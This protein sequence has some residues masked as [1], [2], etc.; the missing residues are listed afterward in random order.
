[1][2]VLILYDS[3]TGNTEKIVN[4][5]YKTLKNY[6]LEKLEKIKITKDFSTDFE[7]LEYDTIFLGSPVIQ[8]LPSVNLMNFCKKT[9]M[10][11]LK[12]GHIIP[13]SPKIEGKYGIPFVSY[14]GMHTGIKEAIPALKYLQQFLEHLR[15]NV[16]DEFYV[17]GEYRS[18]EFQEFNKDTPLGDITG[19]PNENDLKFTENKVKQ[20]MTKI[21]N[22]NK[23]PEI[24]IHIPEILKFF[25][26][27]YPTLKE[28]LFN[29]IEKSNQVKSLTEKETI[30]IMIALSCS[31]KCKECLKHH[32]TNALNIGVTIEEIKDVFLTGFLATGASFV[33]FGIEVLKE[34]GLM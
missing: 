24:K 26:N 9:L 3:F 6:N 28:P 27:E 33:N 10:K 23:Q 8:F 1:M 32:I 14:G 17:V 18:K 7:I 19:R 16:I 31:V 4:I 2:K 5:I 11:Y 13:K 29:Y 12:K 21:Y 20:I 15:F 30:L 25:E 22:Q 34:L